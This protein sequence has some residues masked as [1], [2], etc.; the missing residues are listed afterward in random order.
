MTVILE[1]QCEGQK[2]SMSVDNGLDYRISH[3]L[4]MGTWVGENENLYK[5]EG[6]DLNLA[7]PKSPKHDTN[8]N[9]RNTNCWVY[10]DKE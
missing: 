8:S 4:V 5:L 10:H 7:N 2:Q 1:R 6:K 9:E 3:V